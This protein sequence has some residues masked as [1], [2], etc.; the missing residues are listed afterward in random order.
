MNTLCRDTRRCVLERL[1]Y[2]EKYRLQVVSKTFRDDLKYIIP[3]AN[4]FDIAAVIPPRK[5]E[6]VCVALKGRSEEF[7]AL[8][9]SDPNL[10]KYYP[11]YEMHYMLS[12]TFW[13]TREYRLNLLFRERYLATLFTTNPD[14]NYGEFQ[15]VYIHPNPPYHK[16]LL[17]IT[18]MENVQDETPEESSDDSDFD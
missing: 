4:P 18:H 1:P 11:H 7:R 16:Y 17:E 14:I 3:Y 13:N 6:E 8:I 15:I 5:F 12:Q 9:E 2:L 10:K